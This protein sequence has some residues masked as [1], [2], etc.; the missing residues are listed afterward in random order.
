MTFLMFLK[1]MLNFS[2]NGIL[3]LFAIFCFD[4]NPICHGGRGG[5][6]GRAADSIYCDFQ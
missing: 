1:V 6:G 3:G 2:A 5:V 4:V